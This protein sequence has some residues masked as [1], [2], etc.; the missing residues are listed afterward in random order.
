MPNALDHASKSSHNELP[1]DPQCGTVFKKK[2]TLNKSDQSKGDRFLSLH[3]NFHEV[4]ESG[5]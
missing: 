1:A 4:L 3:I 2:Q 5:D